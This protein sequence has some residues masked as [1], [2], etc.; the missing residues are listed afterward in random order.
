MKAAHFPTYIL[1]VMLLVGLT[2][3]VLLSPPRSVLVMVDAC[4]NALVIVPPCIMFR[5]FASGGGPTAQMNAGDPGAMDAW[6]TWVHLFPP[7]MVGLLVCLAVSVIVAIAALISCIRRG[8]LKQAILPLI[9]VGLTIVH[10]LFA[11]HWV[12]IH[13][14]TA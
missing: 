6:S 13:F 3:V 7:L 11:A 9:Y 10:C 14:P 12:G 8:R 1:V 4:V 5:L 2:F